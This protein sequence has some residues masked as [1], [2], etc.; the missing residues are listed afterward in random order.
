MLSIG[1]CSVAAAVLR[2]NEIMTGKE[3][4]GS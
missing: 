4:P 1:S 2:G 3:D